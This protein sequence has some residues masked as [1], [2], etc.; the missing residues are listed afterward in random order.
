[1]RGSVLSVLLGLGACAPWVGGETDGLRTLENAGWMTPD[2]IVELAFDV[3]EGET[4]FAA[5]FSV[6]DEDLVFVSHLD[7]PGEADLLVARDW[8]DADRNRT[9]AV[10]SAATNTLVWP[11]GAADRPLDPGRWSMEA[12][13]DAPQPMGVHLAIKRDVDLQS[14]ALA[15]RVRLARSVADDPGLA[16]GVDEAVRRWKD[17]IYAPLGVDLDVDF[18]VW[19]GTDVLG[20]PGFADPQVYRQVTADVPL[21]TLLVLV[22]EE[23][24]DGVGIFGASGGIPGPLVPSDRSV[25]T[26]SAL[27]AAGADLAFAGAGRDQELDLFAE[28]IAHE[29]GHYL[30][31]FHPAELPVGGRVSTWDALDDT[32]ECSTFEACVGALGGNLMFPTPLCATGESRC[33]AFVAQRQV[34]SAQAGVVHRN[35]HVR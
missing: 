15:V 9:N 29:V 7:A 12:V 20:S 31:L 33:T 32:A 6:A 14:G 35:P 34:T 5:T 10:F 4:S 25:V 26:I 3:E 23:I 30:G 8:W 1:M 16:D 24:D 13:P 21:R 17:E 18:D 11:I 2:G 19:E 28:T 27:E 22:L